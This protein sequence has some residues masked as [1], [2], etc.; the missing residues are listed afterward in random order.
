M[1]NMVP[2]FVANRPFIFVIVDLLTTE[3]LFGGRYMGPNAGN[4]TSSA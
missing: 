3:S 2:T 1:G 4:P